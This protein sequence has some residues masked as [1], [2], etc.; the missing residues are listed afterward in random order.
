MEGISEKVNT[1]IAKI[2]LEKLPVPL[3]EVAALFNIQVVPYPDFPDNVSGMIM[4]KEGMTFIGVNQNHPKVRQR[5]TLAH[6]LGHF[7][8]G[9]D[10]HTIVDDRFDKP[11]NKEKEANKFASELLMPKQ[12]IEKEIKEHSGKIGINQLAKKFEVSEQAM[13]I[14]LLDTGLIHK[15]H[16]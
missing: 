16:T 14:R 13:S 6:E 8:M 4:H 5:F 3:E 2:G 10:D 12:F 15:L 7:L 11:I 1:I 9:H